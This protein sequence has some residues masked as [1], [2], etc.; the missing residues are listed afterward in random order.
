[1]SRA[2]IFHEE[3]RHFRIASRPNGVWAPQQWIERTLEENTV[4][5]GA[6]RKHDPW[7]DLCGVK[8]NQ[9]DALAVMRS[10]AEAKSESND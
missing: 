8:L 6:R 2:P 4:E 9:I 10:R 3:N 5:D 1:M 7:H